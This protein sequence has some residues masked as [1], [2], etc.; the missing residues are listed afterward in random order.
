MG[1]RK[2]LLA[3]AMLLTVVTPAAADEDNPCPLWERTVFGITTE[4]GL[5]EH[6]FCLDANRTMSRWT[7]DRVVATSGWGDVTAAFWSGHV[8]GTG[9]YYRVVGGGL[10]WSRD[11]QSWQRIGGKTNWSAYTS[12]ISTEPGVIYATEPSGVVHRWVHL[13]WEDGANTWAG[14]SVAG[15]LPG[16]SR[17]LGQTRDGFVGTDGTGTGNLVS[18]WPDGFASVRMRI[19]V[20][21]GVDRA[22]VVPFDLEQQYPDS[23]F[24]LTPV[25]KIVVLLPTGCQKLNRVWKADD[26]TGGGYR[27]IFAGDYLRH[28]AGPVEWQCEGPPGTPVN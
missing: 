23:A 4:G 16:A 14:D 18:V 7:G 10:F 26:E 15:S 19:V 11:L 24:G 28:G 27:S 21:P 3:V 12:L 6:R 22:T 17:L 20:P 2:V 13:G 8:H 25:G 1:L 5:V 9:A